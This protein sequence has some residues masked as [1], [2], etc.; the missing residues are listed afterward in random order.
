[1]V[2]NEG[3]KLLRVVVCSPQ[4]EYFNVDNPAA[5]NIIKQADRLKAIEQHDELKSVMKNFSCE[6][7]DI[8]E[9]ASHPNSVFTRDTM[10]CTPNGYIKLH[11]GL[12][13]RRGEEDW[14]AYA[15][16]ALGE[17]YVDVITEPGTAE[18]GDVIL[19][20]LVAFVGH[21]QR[22]NYE[23]VLQLKRLLS[24]MNY[25][26]RIAQMPSNRL[27]IGG[28]MSM[29][30]QKRIVYCKGVFPP[31]FFEGFDTVEVSSN[32]FISGNVIC[33]SENEVIAEKGNHEVITQLRQ[34]GVFVH[35]IDLSE[36]VKGRGGPTCLIMPVERG[37]KRGA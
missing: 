29:I 27:H 13:T 31:G 14:M 5:H 21:S 34:A 37:K 17:P 16:D 23:G 7:I 4:R 3:D 26:V 36:F 11:M 28:A 18:G 19:A 9:L 2:R 12:V 22:T 33:L 25:E 30:G 35:S 24:S 20:G 32:T 10:V 6:V 15:L 8:P 1:M